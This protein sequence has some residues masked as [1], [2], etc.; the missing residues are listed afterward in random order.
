MLH[1]WNGDLTAPLRL[2]P[3]LSDGPSWWSFALANKIPSFALFTFQFSSVLR[4]LLSAGS[5][6]LSAVS[7]VKLVASDLRSSIAQ[8]GKPTSPGARSGCSHR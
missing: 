3:E 2:E 8:P 1:I 6:L 5:W 4:I 7:P